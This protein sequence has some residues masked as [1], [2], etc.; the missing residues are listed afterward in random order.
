M[1]SKIEVAETEEEA[2]T[3]IAYQI[4]EEAPRI[5]GLLVLIA[6]KDGTARSI[7]NGLTAEESKHFVM[8]FHSWVDQCIGRDAE[9]DDRKGGKDGYL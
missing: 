9:T 6:R 8:S 1:K 2:C 4:V 7:D 3:R 5:K